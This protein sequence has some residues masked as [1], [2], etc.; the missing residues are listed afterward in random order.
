[1]PAFESALR[2]HGGLSEHEA[3]AVG[4]HPDRVVDFSVS[5]NPYG[6]C[7]GVIEAVRAASIDRYPDPRARQ[8]CRAIAACFGLDVDAVA[9]GNG[10]CELLWTLALVLTRNKT[11]V[12]I[13]GPTFSE[14]RAAVEHCGAVVHEWR[15]QPS[16]GFEPDLRALEREV[17]E[18]DASVVYLCSPNTPTGVALRAGEIA[19]FAEAT[20]EATIIVDQSFLSLSEHADDLFVRMPANVVCVRSMTKDHA[21]PGVRVGYVVAAPH[22]IGRLEAARP[23]WSTSTMAQAAALAACQASNFVAES[24][25]KLLEDRAELE[26]LLR[27]HGL[28][29]TPSGAPFIVVNVGDARRLRERLL[30]RHAVLVRDC[31][32]FGLPEW[33]RLAA[34]PKVDR[35][36]LETA[37]KDELCRC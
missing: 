2:I 8:A 33:I 35:E 16:N 5:S 15:V 31:A 23:A 14:F 6:P 36:R 30:R 12:V 26:R 25:S 20:G 37:L 24:R 9:L 1:M 7:S 19:R 32:S 28:D 10:A 34:R 29:P 27:R 3:L 4:V 17:F 11:A 21:I 13:A 18:R 22:F